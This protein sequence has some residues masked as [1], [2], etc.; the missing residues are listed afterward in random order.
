MI[1]E[2]SGKEQTITFNKSTRKNV[3]LRE[4]NVNEED[5]EAEVSEMT[6]TGGEEVQNDQGNV[7]KQLEPEVAKGND[8][9]AP[10]EGE[11]DSV[12]ASKDRTKETAQSEN[13]DPNKAD[14]PVR[15]KVNRRE[16]IENLFTK[17]TVGS[18]FEEARQRYLERKAIKV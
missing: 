11:T 1:L 9:N 18:A 17:R 3:K 8:V 12:E 15:V 14:V 13:E 6:D 16:L 10:G 7:S 4:R 2:L 5:N